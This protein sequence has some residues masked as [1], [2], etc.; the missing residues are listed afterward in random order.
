MVNRMM[1]VV[2]GSAALNV[3][4]FHV[5][6]HANAGPALRFHLVEVFHAGQV[7]SSVSSC[8]LSSFLAHR[9]GCAEVI[10][11][12]DLRC[13]SALLGSSEHCEESQ[14]CNHQNSLHGD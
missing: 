10:D 4:V 1:S 5:G 12:G 7:S 14:N 2:D 9:V 13:L 6:N 8:G 3:D 11:T